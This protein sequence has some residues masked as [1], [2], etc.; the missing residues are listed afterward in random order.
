MASHSP[1]SSSHHHI[2]PVS[3]YF[4][5]ALLLTFL[6]GATILAS[7]WDAGNVWINNGIALIIAISKTIVV[8]GWFMHVKYSTSLTK[9]FAMLGFLWV[10][11][12]GVILVDYFFRGHEPVPSWTGVHDSALPRRIGSSDNLPLT[13]MDQNVQNRLPKYLGN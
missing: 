13:P 4:K 8:V 10:T 2:H 5:A 7:Y 11:L 12:L 9:L 3:M 6:M 1:L